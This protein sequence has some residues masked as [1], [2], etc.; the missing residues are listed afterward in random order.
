MSPRSFNSYSGKSPFAGQGQAPFEAGLRYDVDTRDRVEF[1]TKTSERVYIFTSALA[2]GG[3]A[4][5]TCLRFSTRVV[6][7]GPV[8]GVLKRAL[9]KSSNKPISG[10][11]VLLFWSSTLW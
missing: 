1:C 8:A 4:P 11:A 2:I 7:E 9:T 5:S 6:V 10:K 3:L